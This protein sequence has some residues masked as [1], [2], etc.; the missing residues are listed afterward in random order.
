MACSR[1]RS[2]QD[3]TR[4]VRTGRD[5]HCRWVARPTRVPEKS[6]ASTT[7][8][9]SVGTP[10]RLEQMN[11]TRVFVR[12]EGERALVTA[13]LSVMAAVLAAPGGWRGERLACKCRY[14]ADRRVGEHRHRPGLAIERSCS[15]WAG[16][17]SRPALP[18]PGSAGWARSSPGR[19]SAEVQLRLRLTL[20]RSSERL[21]KFGEGKT[22]FVGSA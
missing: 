9:R 6:M 14:G 22:L 5:R 1:G 15:T 7:T 18:S 17:W 20:L 16:R 8:A 2:V 4:L 11:Y 10:R 19:S 12:R 13:T 3:E 21:R